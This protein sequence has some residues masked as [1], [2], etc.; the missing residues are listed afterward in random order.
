MNNLTPKK[1]SLLSDADKGAIK[2][3]YEY[4][5]TIHQEGILNPVVDVVVSTFPVT[6]A[7]VRTSAGY[8]TGTFSTPLTDAFLSNKLRFDLP[9][10]RVHTGFIIASFDNGSNAYCEL[11][12]GG[13]GMVVRFYNSNREPMDLSS[14]NQGDPFFMPTLKLYI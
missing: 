10:M 3:Y 9:L 13:E 12:L 8:Y 14:F 4:L 1:I 11:D 7:W 5:C 2:G 6:I